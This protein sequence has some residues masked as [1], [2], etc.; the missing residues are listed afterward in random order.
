MSDLTWGPP[1]YRPGKPYGQ[2]RDVVQAGTRFEIEGEGPAVLLIHGV[3]LDLR[4]W[5]PI[6]AELAQ[7]YSVIRY[8]IWGHGESQKPLSQ[9][10][11]RDY[12]SQLADLADYLKLGRFALVGF[13]MGALIAQGYA[14]AR[15]ER[16]AGLCL[17]N[18]VHQRSPE[19]RAVVEARLG[20]AET[21]GPQAII[22]A[23]LS[24]WLSAGC[25]KAHPQVEAALRRRLERNDRA[26]FLSAYRVFA[27]ADAE[28]AGRLS[29]VSCP[30]LAM[31]GGLDS[32]STPEMSRALAAE[33]ADG[34]ALV[35]EGLAHLAPIEGAERC[36]EHLTK[37]LAERCR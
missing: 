6:A 25:R 29:E 15:Q 33:A 36:A 21:E 8:D 9:L 32:G 17:M 27:A 13:S 31:T 24:R 7:R 5:D 2:L 35:L 26:G 11:L 1:G 19:Q 34:E 14:L 23:A 12:V 18:S 20:V 4:M 16:L 28:L 30:L 3:G 37:F 10:K 22:E